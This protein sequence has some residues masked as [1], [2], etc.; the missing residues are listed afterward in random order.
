MSNDGLL[1][2]VSG[3]SGAGKGTVVKE[4]ITNS[5]YALSVSVTTRQPRKGEENGREYFFITK[6]EYHA[7]LAE[8]NLLETAEYVGNFY[9]TP[10][11]YATEQIAIG[12]TV[13]LEIEAVGA[14]QVKE[15][16]PDAVLIFLIPPSL[17]ELENRLVGRN[18]DDATVIKR[19]LKRALEEVELVE[20][21]DYL[22]VNDSVPLAVER[23]NT[24]VAAE[25]LKPQRCDRLIK[26]F[27]N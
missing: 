19:R 8:D 21:Y 12:K 5:N 2:V 22:V 18:T 10:R 3:P 14:L 24:I 17:G 16:F 25:L 7:L 26:N 11:K 13:L 20:N 15:K 6:D 1:V 23:I 27:A 9:G 4:L